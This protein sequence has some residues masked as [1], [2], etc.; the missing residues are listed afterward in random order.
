M[1]NIQLFSTKVLS[2]SVA[3]MLLFSSCSQE[4]AE[5]QSILPNKPSSAKVSTVVGDNRTDFNNLGSFFATVY[6]EGGYCDFNPGTS[7]NGNFSINYNSNNDMVG[8][9]GW[10]YGSTTRKIGYNV[11]SLTGSRDF[12]GVYGWSHSNSQNNLIEYYICEFGSIPAST[13]VN[14]VSSDGHNY[15]FYRNQRSNSPSIEGTKTF[16][17]YIDRWGNATTGTNRSINMATHINNWKAKGVY[18]FTDNLDYQVFGLEAF[19][20]KTG[21]INATVW[22]N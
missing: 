3:F 16:W 18:G 15:N 22:Q 7:A 8:G 12:V 19:G 13:S 11:G 6:K 14:S 5:E 21:Y 20:G 2:Y 17:Q 4:T 10:R 9:K 1:K